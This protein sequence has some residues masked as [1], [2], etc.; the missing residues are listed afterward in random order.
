MNR[1]IHPHHAIWVPLL[2]DM[3]DMQ[4][5]TGLRLAV[6]MPAPE[7]EE[8]L[9]IRGGIWM[10]CSV[11]SAE[12]KATTQIIVETEMCL[13]TVEGR[14]GQNDSEQRVMIKYDD[15]YLLTHE[16]LGG[17]SIS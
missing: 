7:M 13:E 17:S 11:S 15:I 3:A 14:S 8:H 12:R 6:H 10:R 16:L 2:Q 1:S 5:L 9:V 4:T